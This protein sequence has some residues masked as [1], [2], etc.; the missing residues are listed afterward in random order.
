MRCRY[1]NIT[2]LG[3]SCWSNCFIP[4][5]TETSCPSTSILTAAIG[6]AVARLSKNSSSVMRLTVRVGS[7]L[8]NPYHGTI[9]GIRSPRVLKLDSALHIRNNMLM[10]LE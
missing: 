3:L 7:L 8:S 9:A 4:R 10:D 6:E 5:M 2:N 1:S